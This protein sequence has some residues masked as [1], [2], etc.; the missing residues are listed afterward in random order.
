M[1]GAASFTSHQGKRLHCRSAAIVGDHP[2]DR[3]THF[4]AVR[5]PVAL[6]MKASKR[7]KL[8]PAGQQRGDGVGDVGQISPLMPDADRPGRLMTREADQA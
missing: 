5:V 1:K 8:M 6:H 4:A 7:L 3:L 2:L